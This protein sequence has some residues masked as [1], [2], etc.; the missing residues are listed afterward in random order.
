MA[1]LELAPSL[2]SMMHNFLIHKGALGPTVGGVWVGVWG[3][4]G[5][6]TGQ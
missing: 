4:E 3:W 2:G 5:V 6:G 1:S